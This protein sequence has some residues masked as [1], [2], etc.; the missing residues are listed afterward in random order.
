M[1]QVILVSE[2]EIQLDVNYTDDDDSTLLDDEDEEEEQ[3]QSQ[4][5][6]VKSHDLIEYSNHT[7]DAM[8]EEIVLILNEDMEDS[9]E[10]NA[11]IVVKDEEESPQDEQ[12]AA[13]FDELQNL[14]RSLASRVKND[15]P[16]Y[17]NGIETM[18]LQLKGLL[19][20]SDDELRTA[21]V[22]FGKNSSCS[23]SG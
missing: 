19:E 6:E 21:L 12:L 4:L 8:K 17:R 11:F 1:P 20:R 16:Y 23:S 13:T 3:Q 18:N 15:L 7:S 5:L 9:N 14:M 22:D 2:E 10:L